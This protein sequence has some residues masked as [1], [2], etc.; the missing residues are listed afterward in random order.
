MD[1]CGVNQQVT[2]AANT[3]CISTKVYCTLVGTPEA[4]CPPTDYGNKKLN[5]EKI[6]IRWCEWLGGFIDGDGCFLVSKKGYCSLEITVHTKD[7]PLLAQ[8][9][10]RYGGSLKAR[11]G[12]NAVRYRLMHKEGFLLL[13]KD[14]NGFIRHPVRI[15]Q[16][17][18]I[19]V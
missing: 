19:C 14:V 7:E 9:K 15:K 17:Q 16:F 5:I 13:C 1:F 2:N 11:A 6:N 8:I 18:K 4:V 12:I 10:Q 3:L